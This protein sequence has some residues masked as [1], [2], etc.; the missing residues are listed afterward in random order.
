MWREILALKDKVFSLL[1]FTGGDHL[2]LQEHQK[3]IHLS[4]FKP[5]HM[6]VALHG[7]SAN[8]GVFS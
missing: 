2:D 3:Q 7:L 6:S 8:G 5:H 1:A 4:C